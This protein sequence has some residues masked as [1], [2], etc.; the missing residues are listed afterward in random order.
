MSDDFLTPHQGEPSTLLSFEDF[1]NNT[2]IIILFN[3][4]LYVVYLKKLW[5]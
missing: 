5:M 3:W 1:G 4:T 2:F